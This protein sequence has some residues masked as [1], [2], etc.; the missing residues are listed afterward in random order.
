LENAARTIAALADFGFGSLVLTLEDL[1]TPN[2]IIHL[3][4]P[5]NQVDLAT[6]IDGVTFAEAWEGRASGH[7]GA[8]PTF[9]PGRNEFIINKRTVGRPQDLADIDDLL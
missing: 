2:R 4:L 8:Q 6:L 3:G 9:F 1:C 7:Y 5:P